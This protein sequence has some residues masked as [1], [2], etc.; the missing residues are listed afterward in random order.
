MSIDMGYERQADGSTVHGKCKVLLSFGARNGG[1][2]MAQWLYYRLMDGKTY[3]KPNH[4]YLDTFG[5]MDA[6]GTSLTFS[7]MSGDKNSRFSADAL[8]MKPGGVGEKNWIARLKYIRE[9]QG[10]KAALG[11]AT[12]GG[13]AP[14]NEQWAQYY[15]QAMSTCHTMIF[16]VTKEWL[17]SQ[18]CKGELL[19][20]L[21]HLKTRTTGVGGK[22]L[23]GIL[24][25]FPGD[26][27]QHAARFMNIVLENSAD[28]LTRFRLL[29]GDRTYPG[30]SGHAALTGNY[31]TFWTLD[32]RTLSRLCAM[33]P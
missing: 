21:A 25:T 18:F 14:L 19:N 7:I 6:P 9:L 27:P 28:C 15:H 30:G 12:A 26:G 29:Q 20:F 2:M 16:I 3:T 10:N 33:I 1:A 17:D 11:G 5:L 24:V 31:K 4:V 8:E 32:Q 13:L 23:T 22:P